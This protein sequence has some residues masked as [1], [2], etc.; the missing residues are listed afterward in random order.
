MRQEWWNQVKKMYKTKIKC[1]LS[2]VSFKLWRK[3]AHLMLH[4]F[5]FLRNYPPTPPLSQH[6]LPK[7]EVSWCWLRGGVGGQFPRKC[8]PFKR[9]DSEPALWKREEKWFLSFL[10]FLYT[11]SQWYPMIQS[12]HIIRN[13]HSRIEVGV[14]SSQWSLFLLIFSLVNRYSLV[15]K[16]T[17][18][19]WSLA[20]NNSCLSGHMF[21]DL[22]PNLSNKANTLL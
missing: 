7:W 10:P 19:Y 1:W 4:H 14:N 9:N 8:L 22:I 6:F 17:E 20:R 16:Y 5:T 2:D 15:E 13:V 11:I 12:A 18:E 21:S 3:S